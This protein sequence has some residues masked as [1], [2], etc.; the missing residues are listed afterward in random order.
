MKSLVL[1]MAIA[2]Q[3]ATLDECREH[4]R[5]GRLDRSKDCFV[6]LVSSRDAYL[7][8][9]AF[10]ALGDFKTA[11]DRFR[12]AVA[13]KPKDPLPRVRWGRMYLERG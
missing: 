8:G 3:A 5:R 10:W 9:E 6:Q 4:K 12:T 2:A 7:Q 11:N 1:M 13:N